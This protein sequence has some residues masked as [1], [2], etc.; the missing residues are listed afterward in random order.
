MDGLVSWIT[1]LLDS[2]SQFLSTAPLWIQAPLVMIVVIP[3]CAVVTIAWLRFIDFCGSLAT[4]KH[5]PRS[6]RGAQTPHSTPAVPRVITG[7]FEQKA[8]RDG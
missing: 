2:I 5:R 6:Q 8:G 3:L 1:S 7:E 4:R